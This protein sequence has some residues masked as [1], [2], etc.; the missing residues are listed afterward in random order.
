MCARCLEG[1]YEDS[2]PSSFS[3]TNF[4]L[5]NLRW[6]YPGS[7][8][9]LVGPTFNN[10]RRHFRP[11]QPSIRAE[12]GARPSGVGGGGAVANKTRA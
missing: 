3:L 2:L 12:E 8:K 6:D 7:P 10:Q 1:Q 5:L 4:P 9:G 11:R